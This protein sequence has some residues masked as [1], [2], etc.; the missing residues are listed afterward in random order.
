MAVYGRRIFTMDETKS[1]IVGVFLHIKNRRLKIF[2]LV[3]GND[4][5]ES[6]LTIKEDIVETIEE[7]L[8][9]LDKN[10]IMIHVIN[11]SGIIE[12]EIHI[13]PRDVS[14]KLEKESETKNTDAL[15]HEEL[16]TKNINFLKYLKENE[17]ISEDQI[18]IRSPEDVDF[19]IKI[20]E[21]LTS[22]ITEI[23]MNRPELLDKYYLMF[24]PYTDNNESKIRLVLTK[25]NKVLYRT[26]FD[27]KDNDIIINMKVIKFKEYLKKLIND[28]SSR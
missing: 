4:N 7:L 24:L 5:N 2:H 23:F 9:I 6:G 20:N 15:K 18:G 22:E 27:K 1:F 3:K 26:T 19:V 28:V 16:K 13:D 25:D 17:G 12:H 11:K 8:N 14:K 21:L 10:I